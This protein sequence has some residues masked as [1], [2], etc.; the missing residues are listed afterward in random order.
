MITRI[1]RLLVLLLVLAGCTSPD[2]SDSYFPLE[3]G[4]EWR[5]K[6]QTTKPDGS[7]EL[8]NY[9]VKNAGSGKF[10]DKSIHIRRTSN[11][12]DYY[13]EQRSNGIYRVA[14]RIITQPEAVADIPERQVLPALDSETSNLIWNATTAA[15]AIHRTHPYESMVN[16]NI[17]IE[18]AY[19]IE[20]R[21]ETVA[22]PAGRFEHCI[23]VEGT[24]EIS[25]YTDPA[26]GYRDIGLTTTEWYAPGVGLVK[27][28]RNE[29]LNTDVFKGGTVIMELLE[30]DT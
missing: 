26:A 4:L 5:Y 28:I 19:S 10:N 25:L 27:L 29:P 7:V 8:G 20:A 21:D 16:K 11:G 3:K 30:F 2:I 15:Y 13:L 12:T 14:K 18:M 1:T 23:R 24:A 6:L 9:S 17:H 22:V